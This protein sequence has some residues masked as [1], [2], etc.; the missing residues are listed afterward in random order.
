MKIWHDASRLGAAAMIAAGIIGIAAPALAQGGPKASF[1]DAQADRGHAAYSSNG[2]VDCHGAHLNDGEFGGPPLK[3]SSF[4]EKYFNTT[5]DALYGFMSS[6]MPPD[7]PG[8]LN[9]QTYADIMAFIL[10]NNGVQAGA[11]ELP[12]DIDALGKLTVE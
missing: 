4:Q 11:A 12:A 8:Q 6:A 5:A 3:G 2:C 7:R 10:S 1:T 9:P